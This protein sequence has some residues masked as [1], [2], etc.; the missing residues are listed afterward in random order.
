VKSQLLGFFI[1]S[2]VKILE[3]SGVEHSVAHIATF[4]PGLAGKVAGGYTHDLFLTLIP[5]KI[6][7]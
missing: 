4:V 7:L 1:T 6:N 2:A 3:V 5:S